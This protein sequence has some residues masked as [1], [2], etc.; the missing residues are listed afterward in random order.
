[1]AVLLAIVLIAKLVHVLLWLL[2][3]VTVVWLVGVYARHRLRARKRQ[4]P[5]L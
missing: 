2:L 3:A 4:V 5:K 1:M